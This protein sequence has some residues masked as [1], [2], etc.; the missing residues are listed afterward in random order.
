[1]CHKIFDCP[2]RNSPVF[3]TFVL[4]SESGISHFTEFFLASRMTSRK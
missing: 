3:G 2:Q 1:M 4:M